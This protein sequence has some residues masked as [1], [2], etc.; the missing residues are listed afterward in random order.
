M[1]KAKLAICF[2]GLPR[3]LSLTAGSIQQNLIAPLSQKAALQTYA[4]LYATSAE[5]GETVPRDLQGL[6]PLTACQQETPAE[7]SALDRYDALLSHGDYW[8]NNGV[9]LRNLI[10]QL[11]SLHQV[12]QMALEAGAEQCLFARPD[13]LYHDSLAPHMDRLL[14]APRDR[15]FLPTWQH[16]KGGLNDRMAFCNGPKAIRAYGTRLELALQFC[17]DTQSPLHSEQLVAYTLWYHGLRWSPLPMRATRVRSDG[18]HN[19]ED[20]GTNR[21]R[22]ARQKLRLRA[23][24]WRLG[25]PKEMAR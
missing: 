6:L 13:L 8:D 21:L 10:L 17:Q 18:Q 7:C 2:F 3:A 23:R 19:P 1:T 5:K 22:K 4:H 11:H 20:F 14:S 12:T 15:V 9:S 16:W 25:V 24:W